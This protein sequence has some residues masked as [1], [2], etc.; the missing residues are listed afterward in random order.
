[1]VCEG[2]GR[3]AQVAYLQVLEDS[4]ALLIAAGVLP[5]GPFP[6]DEKLKDGKLSPLDH[7]GFSLP[8]LLATELSSQEAPQAAVFSVI[9]QAFLQF[10]S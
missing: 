4:R 10:Q 3:S 2:P 1:M 8:S 9:L 5:E 7:P 6:Q